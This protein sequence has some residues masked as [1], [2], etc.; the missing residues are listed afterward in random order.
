MINKIFVFFGDF[1]FFV[2]I[3]RIFNVHYIVGNFLYY[4][5]Y[6]FHYKHIVKSKFQFSHFFPI[7]PNFFFDRFQKKKKDFFQ[8]T[9]LPKN[10]GV[11]FFR[12]APSLVTDT[13]LFL[14]DRQHGL[15]KERHDFS[16]RCIFFFLF[17]KKTWK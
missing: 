16:L 7:R 3:C 8:L 9:I 12:C 10:G 14:R 4:F 11:P 2:T 13:P 6:N 5:F 17:Y 1:H 15:S